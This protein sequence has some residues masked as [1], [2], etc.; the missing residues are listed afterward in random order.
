MARQVWS[1]AY[2]AVLSD[3]ADEI[4][5]CLSHEEIDARDA[6]CRTL[7]NEEFDEVM[8]LT[9]DAVRETAE[10]SRKSVECN[11]GET[12]VAYLIAVRKEMRAEYVAIMRIVAGRNDKN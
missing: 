9:E 11:E 6:A 7:S 5:P 1:R 2:M 10:A 8:Y 3:Q 12:W 4:Q